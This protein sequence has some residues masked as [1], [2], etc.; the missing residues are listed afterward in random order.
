MPWLINRLRLGRKEL[1]EG[2]VAAQPGH[3]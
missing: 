2:A 1:H 3:P